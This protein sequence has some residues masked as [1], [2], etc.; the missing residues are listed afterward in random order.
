MLIL[1][2]P[3]DC[4]VE[5]F[6]SLLIIFP[7]LSVPV[8]TYTSVHEESKSFPFFPLFCVKLK[9]PLAIDANVPVDVLSPD[10]VNT[11]RGIKS[12]S[13]LTNIT[14]FSCF[15]PLGST[16]SPFCTLLGSTKTKLFT[17]TFTKIFS[18]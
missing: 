18:L 5:S 3:K 9:V 12:A 2:I 1:S 7:S 17:S 14:K 4:A 11:L 13:R 15:I 6:V 10:A 16:W 8:G